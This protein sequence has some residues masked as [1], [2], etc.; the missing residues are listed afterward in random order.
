MTSDMTAEEL[1]QIGEIAAVQ[2]GKPRHDGRAWGELDDDM[3]DFITLMAAQV[4]ERIRQAEAAVEKRMIASCERYTSKCCEQEAAAAARKAR[5]EEREWCA[6][7]ADQRGFADLARSI[8][9]RTDD[10][11]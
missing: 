4:Q 7:M 10:E 8:R 3:R 9:A 1:F 11:S 6:A 2:T 5:E